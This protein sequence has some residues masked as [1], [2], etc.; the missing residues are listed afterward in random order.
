MGTPLMFLLNINKPLEKGV[1]SV[2]ALNSS[3]Q[4]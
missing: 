4:Y 1:M 3:S 2:I